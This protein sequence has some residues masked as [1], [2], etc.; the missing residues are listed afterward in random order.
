LSIHKQTTTTKQLLYINRFEQKLL[1]FGL[2]TK[3]LSLTET[4]TP[5]ISR[6]PL[7]SA[8]IVA[9]P[10]SYVEAREAVVAT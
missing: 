9:A 5:S 8:V 2:L 6:A 1:Q 10:L 3:T 7:A 4:V